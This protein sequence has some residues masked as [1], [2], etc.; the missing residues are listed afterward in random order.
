M[1]KNSYTGTIW[2]CC[3]T[4]VALLV[5]LGALATAAHA[6][7]L[8]NLADRIRPGQ[9]QLDYQ[10]EGEFKPLQYRHR[11][12]GDSQVCIGNDPR[13]H[14][15]DWLSRKGCRIDRESLQ[16]NRYRIEG[17][18]RLKWLKGHPIAAD[19]EIVFADARSFEL[20]I[21]SRTDSLLTYRDVTR[22]R[23]LGACP[24]G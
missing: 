24:P 6:D 17:E 21:H 20:S 15:R 11:E 3:K 16:G 13:R 14:I 10:R 12:N 8:G 23:R 22:A 1:K 7:A 4:G 2:P 5:C 18:C 9:W 19:V